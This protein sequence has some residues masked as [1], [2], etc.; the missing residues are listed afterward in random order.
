MSTAAKVARH[1]QNNPALYCPTGRCL[2]RTGGGP[3]PRHCKTAPDRK[4]DVLEPIRR[5][6]RAQSSTFIAALRENGVL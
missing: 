2:W 3:C 1:K 4:S 6:A 5:A